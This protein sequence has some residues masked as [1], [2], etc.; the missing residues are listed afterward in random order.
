VVWISRLARGNILLNSASRSW[1]S[2]AGSVKIWN[3][4]HTLRLGSTFTWNRFWIVHQSR[5]AEYV[6]NQRL[7]WYTDEPSVHAYQ[8]WLLIPVADGCKA[9]MQKVDHGPTI[10]S[11]S[12]TVQWADKSW[13]HHVKSVSEKAVSGVR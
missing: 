9:V 4:D 8:V 6:P 3:S 7:A 11:Y 2:S 10:A 12:Q 1:Y 13:V 5:V